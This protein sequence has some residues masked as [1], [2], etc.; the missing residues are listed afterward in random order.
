MVLVNCCNDYIPRIDT[1]MSIEGLRPKCLTLKLILIET[2]LC[3]CHWSHSA[4]DDTSLGFMPEMGLLLPAA[5]SRSDVRDI[6]TSL[7]SIRADQ[8]LR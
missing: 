5:I 7:R 1:L 8:M 2:H 3:P 6:K 4:T